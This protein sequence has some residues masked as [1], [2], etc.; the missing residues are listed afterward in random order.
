MTNA[1]LDSLIDQS[2]GQ[3]EHKRDYRVR[4]NSLTFDPTS[5]RLLLDSAPLHYDDSNPRPNFDV[6][7]QELVLTDEARTQLH[8][9]LGPVHYGRGSSKSLPTEYLDGFSRR[10]YATILNDT[11]SRA[12]TNNWKIRTYDDKCRAVLDAN[13]PRI[14]NSDILRQL[15]RVL[16]E[17]GKMDGMQCHRSFVTPDQLFARVW[18]NGA[19]TGNY[20][21]GFAIANGETGNRAFEGYPLIQRGSCENSIIA[22]NI[23]AITG[24]QAGFRII[25]YAGISAEATMTQFYA[26]L[27]ALMGAS[28]QL[29]N[30]MIEAEKVDMPD[31]HS[32][33]QGLAIEHGWKGEMVDLINRGTEGSFTQGGIVNGVTFAAHESIRLTEPERAEMEIVGGNLLFAPQREFVRLAQQGRE[34]KRVRVPVRA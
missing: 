18:F 5:G 30:R 28:A 17:Q 29:I 13:Y 16:T 24:E 7:H 9:K 22:T 26:H 2:S 20:R 3:D 1:V 25:H 12:T 11:L 14:W 33:L 31:F 21:I 19:G 4:A 15:R 32:I 34:G 10:M 23:S 27:P 8:N 6:Q